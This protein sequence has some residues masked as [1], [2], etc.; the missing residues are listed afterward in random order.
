MRRVRYQVLGLGLVLCVGLAGC[1][2][3]VT[4]TNQGD[5]A[6]NRGGQVTERDVEDPQAFSRRETGLWD[7]RPSLGGVWVAHPEATTPERVII[8][9]IE[10]GRDTVGALFRRE[11]MNPGPAFQISGEAANVLE[12]LA[13]APTMIEVVA[14]RTEEVAT[15]APAPDE[16]VDMARD[17]AARAAQPAPE[18][19]EGPQ[20]SD[21]AMTQAPEAEPQQAPRGGFLSRLFGGG[22]TAQPAPRAETITATE[23]DAPTEATETPPPA[24]AQ[25]PAPAAAAAPS[26]LER[27]FIQLG[28]FSVEENARNAERM[29]GSAGLSARVV[30]G[31]AQGNAFWRVVVGPAQSDAAQ[32][33][34]RARVKSLGFNDAYA[35]RR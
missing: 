15:A 32:R 29:A 28:I 30:E 22:R 12:V 11:R 33:Q 27:P 5:R 18:A 6:A 1:T 25:P 14:L 4:S 19:A 21:P 26:A 23:I 17:D 7:G 24:T 34:M 3:G 35:V 13:G 8:R 31:S 10:T 16:S 20:P 2:D 9:N